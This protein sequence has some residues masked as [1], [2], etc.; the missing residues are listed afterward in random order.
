LDKP[1]EEITLP[2]F[3]QQLPQPINMTLC[4]G[5]GNQSNITDIE[6][7]TTGRVG[8][9]R[10]TKPTTIFMVTKNYNATGLKLNKQYLKSHPELKVILLVYDDRSTMYKEN[11]VRL[12]PNMIS[13]IFE[14]Q[15]CYG[16]KLDLKTLYG[17]LEDRGKYLFEDAPKTTKFIEHLHLYKDY[18]Q[19]F[20]I[21]FDKT[22]Y[23]I[24]KDNGNRLLLNEKEGWVDFNAAV[25]GYKKTT[26]NL[27][28]GRK[29]N[30]RKTIKR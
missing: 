28:G 23:S 8:F 19:Y 17:I 10:E 11:L 15:S 20:S 2:A 14:D 25:K 3:L 22:P 27:S 30:K 18:L 9:K 16:D 1:F 13:N 21:D 24:I 7:F 26:K 12:F 5:D 4:A 29:R 6:W